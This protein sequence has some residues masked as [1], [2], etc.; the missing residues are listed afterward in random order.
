MSQLTVDEFYRNYYCPLRL[1]G[2]SSRTKDLYERTVKLFTEYLS[3]PATLADF[4]DDT[5]NRFLAWF[6]DR[7][8][9]PYTVNKERDN[10]LA[11]WR[12]AARKGFV[13]QWPDVPP[14]VEPARIPLAWTEAELSK[15]FGAIRR[16]CGRIGDVPASDFWNALHM[17]AWDSGERISAMMDLRGEWLDLAGG[18]LVVPAAIRK[19]RTAD[20][21]FKL[22]PD[23]VA[24]LRKLSPRSGVPVF[25]WP[26]GRTYL[27]KKY[28]RVLEDAKLPV[29]NKSKFHRMRKS[30]ASHYEAAGGDATKLLGHSARKVTLAYLD[31]R[32]VGEKHAADLLFRPKPSDP[33][34]PK[35]A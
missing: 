4:S 16:Q 12:F 27:W 20:M 23:T 35:A 32:I 8:C 5:A 34:P 19:G 18:W 17:V 33:E 13:S 9:S 3:R 7:G 31:P 29:N 11:V 30:V 10:L 15:L 14:E 25:Y 6:S 24:A 1:R 26:Y 22:A 28:E 21:L 2:R